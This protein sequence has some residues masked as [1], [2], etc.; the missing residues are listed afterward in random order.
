MRGAMKENTETLTPAAVA[1]L[2][3]IIEGVRRGAWCCCPSSFPRCA[4]D[5]DWSCPS[6]DTLL[7]AASRGFAPPVVSGEVAQLI[8][9]AKNCM[10]E[11]KYHYEHE[12]CCGNCENSEPCNRC[13][14]EI[15]LYKI[16]RLLCD[17]ISDFTAQCA[18]AEA[19]VRELE[20]KIAAMESGEEPD[21]KCEGGCD[22]PVMRHDA[23]MTPLCEEC[24]QTLLADPDV[25]CGECGDPASICTEGKKCCDNCQHSAARAALSASP[26]QGQGMPEAVSAL[27]L[28]IQG[29]QSPH[30]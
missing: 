23:D 17:A 13:E 9:E 30:E 21:E 7:S 1:D 24:W 12:D 11:L 6:K 14:D 29:N 16:C 26:S 4:N 5:H 18:A 19:R 20:R 8:E 15:D 22:A 2:A 3:D 27:I 25:G 28:R 10:E